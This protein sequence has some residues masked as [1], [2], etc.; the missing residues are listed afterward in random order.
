MSEPKQPTKSPLLMLVDSEI[1]ARRFTANALQAAGC[2]VALAR[3]VA[4]A[5]EMIDDLHFIESPLDG[6]LVDHHLSDGLGSRVVQDFQR[7][8]PHIPTAIIFAEDDIVL[9]LWSR[10]RG[11]AL[12]QK[13]DLWNELQAWLERF[14]FPCRP[15]GVASVTEPVPNPAQHPVIQQKR[16]T[17]MRIVAAFSIILLGMLSGCGEVAKTS[18]A[19]ASNSEPEVLRLGYFANVT[20]AQAIL[21]VANGT[22]QKALGNVKLKTSVFNAGPS[23]V[24][25]LFAGELDATYIGPGPASNAIIKSH[26]EAVRVVAGS[27]ANGV[28]LVVRKGAGISKLEDLKGKRIATPQHGAAHA[29]TFLRCAFVLH[30]LHDKTKQDGGTTEIEAVANAEQ[31]GLFKQGQLDASWA[32]EPWASRLVKEAG[33]EVLEEEKN[34]WPEKRFAITLLVVST[35]FLDKYP[36]VVE[37]LL[38]AHVELTALL[39]AHSAENE[40]A[41]NAEFEKLLGKKIAPDV[42]TQAL[43]RVEFTTDPLPATVQ[44]F[45]DWSTELGFSKEKTDLKP[46]FDLKILERLRK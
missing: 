36:N 24:E 31:V 25:A 8:Y 2:R 15:P 40:T 4:E 26:G 3:S 23:A 13:D 45:S 7:E 34:L 33:G 1:E 32:P 35:K 42:L 14:N 16:G 39:H 10:A 37:R 6:L 21:G 30:T 27:A 11:I 44:T 20:H 28:T 29:G 19:A 46:L 43:D 9:R 17:N 12:F 38:K 41:L 22:Y 5:R 18:I